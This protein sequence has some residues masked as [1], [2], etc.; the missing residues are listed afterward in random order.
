MMRDMITSS[1]ENILTY[2]TSAPAE[3]SDDDSMIDK[4]KISPKKK[5][6]K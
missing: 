6:N 3:L 1:T 4:V 5:R 2:V